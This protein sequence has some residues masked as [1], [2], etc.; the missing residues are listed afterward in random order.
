MKELLLPFLMMGLFIAS[1]LLPSQLVNSQDLFDQSSTTVGPYNDDVTGMVTGNEII[2]LIFFFIFW[3]LWK[4]F[5]EGK[6][7]RRKK[8]IYLEHVCAAEIIDFL[9]DSLPIKRCIIWYKCMYTIIYVWWPKYDS[10]KVF[11]VLKKWRFPWH[12]LFFRSPWCINIYDN[13][14]LWWWWWMNGNVC[15]GKIFKWLFHF[16]HIS[17][18]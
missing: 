1:F 9:F 13:N 8:Y 2:T 11:K 18:L 3:K 15:S 17:T 10:E 14:W 6:N 12:R 5:V 16:H 7:E 4:K